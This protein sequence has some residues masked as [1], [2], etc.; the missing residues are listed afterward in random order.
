MEVRHHASGPPI[1]SISNFRCMVV[2]CSRCIESEAS[3]ISKERAAASFVFSTAFSASFR[4][5][6]PCL[7]R[8]PLEAAA[9][10][11]AAAASCAVDIVLCNASRAR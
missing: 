11:A 10:A 8:R 9:A 3:S 2:I 7:K 6:L 5:L 1:K 4:A